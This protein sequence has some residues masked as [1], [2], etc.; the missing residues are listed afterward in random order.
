MKKKS[1]SIIIT[2][3]L[4]FSTIGGAMGYTYYFYSFDGASH[5]ACHVAGGSSHPYGGPT[6]A[7]ENGTIV[8]TST[9][10][11]ISQG[12][13]QYIT[14][15]MEFTISFYIRN[16]TEI[17]DPE[18]DALDYAKLGRANKTQIFISKDLGDNAEFMH[19]IDD[20]PFVH[21]AAVNITG[22]TGEYDLNLRAPFAGGTYDIV[23][24]AFSGI[25]HTSGNPGKVDMAIIYILE[26]LTITVYT[27]VPVGAISTSSSDDDDDDDDAEG[28]ISGYIL[29]IT[30]ATIFSV[31]AILMLSMKKR[32]KNKSRNV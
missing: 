14:V 25:N 28:A 22:D 10:P 29:I 21:N 15:G 18:H 31:S 4:F 11:D 1:I 24:S 16:F 20:S 8:I 26:T 30:L 6:I 23:I 5:G 27:S 32:M 9:T 12:S 19:D 7:S 2:M 17:Y 3:A 13:N